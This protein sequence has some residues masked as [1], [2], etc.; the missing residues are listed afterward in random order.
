MRATNQRHHH[1][2]GPRQRRPSQPA[3]RR[4]QPRL[5]C[6]LGGSPK[7]LES[8][9]RIGRVFCLQRAR[10]AV[11][12]RGTTAS[13]GG[14]GRYIDVSLNS[15]STRARCAPT[16]LWSAGATAN[17]G[18]PTPH[19]VEFSKPSPRAK[20]HTCALRTSGEL[21]CWGDNTD[22]RS[23]PPTGTYKAVTSG[24]EFSCAIRSDGALSCWGDNG[25][26][27][28]S[29][30]S[31]AFKATAAGNLHTCAIRSDGTIACW[32]YD[33][34]GRATPPNGTFIDVAPGSDH[35]CAVGTSGKIA[36]WGDSAFG[37]TSAPDGNYTDVAVGR[38]HSCGLQTNGT[39]TCWGYDGQGR[40]SPPAV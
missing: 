33:G 3:K 32:G 37:K 10:S 38:S 1:L 7:C 9:M 5:T 26:G 22:G 20:I 29:A 17:T 24:G 27:K 28:T 16:A 36:C 2:L 4:H 30:P 19:R 6:R 12:V 40:A 39:I 35:S 8:Q 34:S 25:S 14:A 23:T 21:E 15:S 13:P 11:G 31:G 18:A